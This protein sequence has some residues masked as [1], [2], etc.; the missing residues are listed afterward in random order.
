MLNPRPTALIFD[1]DG[2]L[3]DTLADLA[4]CG[5]L[6][7]SAHGFPTHPQDAYRYFVGDGVSAL[8]Q[9]ATGLPADAEQIPEL[10]AAYKRIYQERQFDQVRLYDGI[11]EALDALRKANWRL[12][13]LSNK[14]D[15]FTQ[16][17]VARLFPEGTFE[18]IRGH[19]EGFPHKP[20]P[21]G[22]GWI[23]DR[24]G[25]PP[26]AFLY[27]GDTATDMQTAT[28]A[29]M[30]ALGAAWGFRDEAELSAHGARTILYAPS[31]LPACA[32]ALRG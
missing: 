3:A 14:P 15:V 2:T 28:S 22:A 25:L 12:A 27:L 23:A 18:Y 31:E 4:A 11:P 24:M 9:R 17:M 5:N 32:Q 21:A 7:L 8:I 19:V 30:Y 1:L 6:V 10:C 29:G 26:E 13:V 20:D 16:T